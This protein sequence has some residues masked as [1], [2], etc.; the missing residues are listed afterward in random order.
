MQIAK[1]LR[2]FTSRWQRGKANS[3]I[4]MPRVPEWLSLL[5]RVEEDLNALNRTTE[6]DFLAVG[7]MLSGLMSGARAMQ[8]E[9]SASA[10]IVSGDKGQSALLTLS[11]VLQRAREMVQSVQ[12]TASDLQQVNELTAQVRDGFSGFQQTI[13]S[14]RLVATLARI[15]TERL[16]NTES[17]LGHLAE[18]FRLHTTNVV[19]QVSELLDDVSAFE[20]R[21]ESVS[22]SISRLIREKA[23]DLPVLIPNIESNLEACRLRQTQGQQASK[24]LASGFG[25]LTSAIAE[26]VGSIQTHDITRQQIE[27]VAEA[28]ADVRKPAVHKS[29]AHRDTQKPSG[30]EALTLRVQC[31]QLQS[32]DQLFTGS[33]RQID[34][35]LQTASTQIQQMMASHAALVHGV[36]GDSESFFNELETCFDAVL[37]AIA[38]YVELEARVASALPEFWSV[39]ARLQ[40]SLTDVQSMTMQVKWLA[41]NARIKAIHLGPSG[42]PLNIVA[43]S[44]QGL[45]TDCESRCAAAVLRVQGMQ[46]ILKSEAEGAGAERAD[47]ITGRV[48]ELVLSLRTASR[49]NQERWLSLESRVASLR[50]EIQGGRDRLAVGE[51]V[52]ATIRQCAKQLEPFA[53]SADFGGGEN[54]AGEAAHLDEIAARYTM[55]SER[56]I[57]RQLAAET[58]QFPVISGPVPADKDSDESEFG[59]NVELF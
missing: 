13:S 16:G 55:Q 29:A 46:R 22:T 44:M 27:H 35:Q 26:I 41:V 2:R 24:E 33:V 17:D 34:T 32:A 18:E 12:Q 43:E 3:E 23:R 9:L 37:V 19:T 48:K 11:S 21:I 1:P 53:A 58:E 59:D 54:Q 49:A 50:Q 25:T 40:K 10:E 6:A 45:Q 28:L 39:L 5:A 15:E 8:G 52:S 4:G 31:A 47:E 36:H 38:E 57:H 30:S 42:E 14:F 20:K 7:G 51:R 56:E